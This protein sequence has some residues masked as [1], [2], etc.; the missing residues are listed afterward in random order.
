MIT[1]A[2]LNVTPKKNMRVV[3]IMDFH[4]TIGFS[5]LENHKN[6]IQNEK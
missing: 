6:Y 3:A 1:A 4:L 5:T 2:I